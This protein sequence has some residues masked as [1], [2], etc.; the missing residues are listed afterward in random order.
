MNFK[1]WLNFFFKNF[2][3]IEDFE[4][5]YTLDYF[6]RNHFSP[7]NDFLKVDTSCSESESGYITSPALSPNSST[8]CSTHKKVVTCV[9]P[10]YL[11][12]CIFYI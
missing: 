1:C 8:E 3:L 12:F 5:I 4:K 6:H 10:L 2:N 11:V 9:Y 7:K